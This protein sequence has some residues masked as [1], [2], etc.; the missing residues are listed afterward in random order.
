[1]DCPGG[2]EIEADLTIAF[3]VPQRAPLWNVSSTVFWPALR[4]RSY[5]SSP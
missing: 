4:L 1:M 2:D 3:I 5:G